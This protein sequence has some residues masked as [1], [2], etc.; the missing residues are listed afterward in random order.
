MSNPTTQPLRILLVDDSEFVRRGIHA[1][2]A[3]ATN[4]PL[5]VVGEAA[6]VAEAVAKAAATSP[7]VVLMDIRLPDG[8]GFDA[9]RQI[10]LTK[11]DT[12]VIVLTS[13]S[14]DG[15]VY[16]AIASGARAYLM[17]EIEPASFLQAIQDVAEGRSILD[18]EATGRVFRLIRTGQPGET[19]S[20]MTKLSNQERRVLASLADGLTNK[21]IGGQ[22]GLS[23]NTVKNYLVSV[24]EKLGVKRRS[25]AAA[26]YVQETEV[27]PGPKA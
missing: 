2:L 6:S 22:L 20:A 21:E 9:C 5:A 8:T 16:E 3:L 25:Q 23:E 10:L 7:D 17:K 14:N 4:P 26:M 19:H 1:V 15:L 18:P 11:P 13:H 24:F 27:R 12:K